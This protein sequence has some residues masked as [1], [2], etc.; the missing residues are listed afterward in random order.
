MPT[1]L[2]KLT[3]ILTFLVAV[4]LITLPFHAFLSVWLASIVGHYTAVRLWKELVLLILVIKLGWTW[5]SRIRHLTKVDILWKLIISYCMLVLVSGLVAYMLHDV[6]L[7]AFAY[8]LVI[9]TRFL[10]FLIVVALLGQETDWLQH[11]WKQL[12][13]IPAAGVIVFGLLQYTLL[14]H[15][16]LGHFGYGPGT[17]PVTATVDQ[18]TDYV[19]IGSTLRGANPL[20][21][22]LVLIIAAFLALIVRQ[23]R[24]SARSAWPVQRRNLLVIG[25]ALSLIVLGA[26]YSRSAWIGTAV[27]LG[28]LI[29]WSLPSKKARQLYILGVMVLIVIGATMLVSLRNNSNFENTIFHTDRNSHSLQSS[30][31]GHASALKNGLKDMFKHP[32]GSGTGTAGPASTYNNHSP[33]IAENYFIQVGQET[34]WLGLVLFIAIMVRVATLLRRK[35]ADAL[36]LLLLASLAG[37]VIVNMLSHAWADDTLAYVWWGFVGIALNM[38]RSKHKSDKD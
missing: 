11:H 7:K 21:A 10:V 25:L 17:I 26:T 30:N 9:D 22:Y 20:G 4:I 33:R 1:T 14:P 31:A 35:R 2:Y 27:S 13:L 16:F 19:R 12:L 15:N 34:G 36:S 38:P 3:N 8:G 29:W 6:S 18:K 5:R 37:L 32:L 23:K 24:S 28:L